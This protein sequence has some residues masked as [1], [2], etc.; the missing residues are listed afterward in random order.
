MFGVFEA[1]DAEDPATVTRLTGFFN[2]LRRAA[3]GAPF[4]NGDVPFYV[5]GLAPNAAR[6]SVRFWVTGTVQQFAERLGQ[7]LADLE[8]AGAPR[9]MPPITL[10]RIV[11]Q[12]AR[13]RDEIQPL[14]G[15]AVLQAV[16][17][18]GPYPVSLAATVLRRIRADGQTGGVNGH[19]RAAILKA[20]LVRNARRKKQKENI[21]MSLDKNCPHTAYHLGRLFAALE[22]TQ[23]DALGG[24]LNVT[25][26]DRY[27]S[28]ASANPVAAF[29]RLLRLH[30]HHLD[31]LGADKR[32]LK[33]VREKLVQ[34]IC[35]HLNAAE[36]FPPHLP[37]DEQGL[38][39]IG[40]YHQ[41]QDFFAS[42]QS[43]SETMNSAGSA[44]GE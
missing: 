39:F 32:G 11:D 34:E 15:G 29:P 42:R 22:K 6:V 21:T 28:S 23:E 16:L 18:G 30:A 24:D 13:E 41:R 1:Q 44:Q 20:Y 31:K 8:L 37:L 36:G 14:L 35:D 3:D 2:R 25:I 27:F 12:T 5:L 43:G 38:F 33:I 10:Q 40:Y 4:E 17:T 26:K 7:H 9:T 19:I